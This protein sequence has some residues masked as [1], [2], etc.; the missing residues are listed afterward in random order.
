MTEEKRNEFTVM[1][2]EMV[3]WLNDNAN[4]HASIIITPTSAE[5]LRSEAGFTTEEF[6][7]D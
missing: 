5:P 7:N 2:K 6:L 4:P 3:K 1:A